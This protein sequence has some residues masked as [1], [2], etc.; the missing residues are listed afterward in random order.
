MDELEYFKNF[1]DGDNITITVDFIDNAGNLCYKYKKVL[2]DLIKADKE[3]E[4]LKL[5][6]KGTTHCYDEEEH[7]DLKSRIDKATEY[8]NQAQLGE[9]LSGELYLLK[10]DE[11]GKKLLKILQGN[12]KK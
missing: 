11:V 10:N 4:D 8:I 6:L 9:L 2:D 5:Q 3:N 7:R 12:D 1:Q